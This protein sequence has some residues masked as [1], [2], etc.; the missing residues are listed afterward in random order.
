MTE[1]R[2][3]GWGALS[4][5]PTE[6]YLCLFVIFCLGT[7]LLLWRKGLRE[8]LRYSAMLLL[9]EWVVV[10]LCTAVFFR[11]S[12]SEMRINLI[13]LSSYFDIPENSYLMEVTAIN[14]LNVV[15]F[16]PV[17]FL[18]GVIQVTSDKGEVISKG[19]RTITKGVNFND[20]LDLNEGRKTITNQNS[21]LI[22]RND[23]PWLRVLVFGAG[24]SVMIE[25]LQ[26]IFKRGLCETDDVIHNV[27]GCMIGYGESLL[28]GGR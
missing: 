28:Y 19:R 5:I 14:I 26:L 3:Y 6:V 16:I 15:L 18:L 10:I 7:G 22:T 11:G 8:G 23:R 27:V 1:L 2:V 20:N 24:I 17:G 9:V 21:K 4:D 25:L 12:S 13:P